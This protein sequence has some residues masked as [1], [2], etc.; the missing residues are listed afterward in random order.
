MTSGSVKP[1]SWSGSDKLKEPDVRRKFRDLLKTARTAAQHDGENFD[2]ILFALERLGYFLS[3]AAEPN[4]HSLGRYRNDICALLKLRHGD[5]DASSWWIPDDRLYDLVERG[6]NDA[7][8]LGA[9]ARHL[10]THAI[11]LSL[12]MEEVLVMKSIAV[13]DF[14]VAHPVCGELWQPLQFLRK[15][16]IENSFSHLPVCEGEGKDR[17]WW[18][19]SDYSLA[20]YL[21]RESFETR[22]K[23]LKDS[24]ADAMKDAETKA[25]LLVKAKLIKPDASVAD[26]LMSQH[27]ALVCEEEDPMRLLGI[28]T[29]FDLL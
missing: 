29:A 23:R 12:R 24:L 15:T 8:H 3:N 17:V 26:V 11:D 16:M 13:R 19:V 22:A 25:Q 10:T 9:A 20:R 2:G 6:R 27:P 5:Q 14:M 7:L 4:N 1:N 28:I 21:G 18:L